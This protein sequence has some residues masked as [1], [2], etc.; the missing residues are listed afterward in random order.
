MVSGEQ[1]CY[2]RG[3]T[4]VE[5]VRLLWIL[6]EDSVIVTAGWAPDRSMLRSGYGDGILQVQRHLH[7]SLGVRVL[8]GW[9]HGNTAIHDSE[10]FGLS[11]SVS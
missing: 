2:C 8:T 6:G 4:R 1:S 5:I 9:Q 7:L 3:W 11:E 10:V